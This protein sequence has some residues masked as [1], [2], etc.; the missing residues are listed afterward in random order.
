MENRNDASA[1]ATLNG[2]IHR[3]VP[4]EQDGLPTLLLLHGTGG[5][6]DALL[7]LGRMLAPGAALL[8]PRGKVLEYGM[9]RYFRR[10]AEGVFDV[11]DLIERTHE[12]AE[13]IAAA[14][15]Q[16]HLDERRIVAVGYSNG[17]NI[18]SSLLLLHP[19]IFSGAALFHPMVPFEPEQAPDLQKI[20][21]F[22]GAGRMDPIAQPD[23]TERLIALLRRANAA[24]TIYWTNGGH[25]LSHEEVRQ[26]RAWINTIQ[27]TLD[28]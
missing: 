2:F 22:I 15:A 7:E 24:L 16:Y 12:L 10:L 3:F 28:G 4:A 17:A 23:N 6:E 21:I 13:F 14:C 9:P 8:S 26:A 27:D 5:T 19:G 25:E 1:T 20:P 11:P 18:A